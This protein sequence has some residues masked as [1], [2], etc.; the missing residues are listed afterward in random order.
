[1]F[2][3][4][5]A[6]LSLA[7]APQL[8]AQQGN[9]VFALAIERTQLTAINYTDEPHWLVLENGSGA[10]LR[11]IAPHSAQAWEFPASCLV[12]VDVR[13]IQRLAGGWHC[14]ERYSLIDHDELYF[15]ADARA[16]TPKPDALQQGGLEE[17]DCFHVPVIR[18]ESKPVGGLPPKIGDKPLP[19]V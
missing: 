7:S 4:L 17:L 8:P 6:T 2:I 16:F 19:P 12:D 14:S 11:R 3:T 13:T 18:P 5:A 9:A 10:L 1:M 15:S